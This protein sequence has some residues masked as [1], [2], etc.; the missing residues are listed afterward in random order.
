MQAD[1]LDH[2]GIGARAGSLKAKA[3]PAQ[4]QAID[5]AFVRLTETG[6]TGMGELFKA[7]AFSDPKL[8]ALPGFDT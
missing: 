1:F 6:A 8:A 2:L 7:I 3:T 5:A 4:T